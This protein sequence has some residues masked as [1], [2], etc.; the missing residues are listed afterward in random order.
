MLLWGGFRAGKLLIPSLKLEIHLNWGDVSVEA[1]TLLKV[2]LKQSKTDQLRQ[3]VDVFVV[4]NCA[5]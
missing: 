1:P 4:V 3:G 2:R 5:Q